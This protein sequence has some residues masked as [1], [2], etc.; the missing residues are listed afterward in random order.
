M[1]WPTDLAEVAFRYNLISPLLDPAVPKAEKKRHRRRLVTVEHSH[2]TRGSVKISARTIRRWVR[3]Y[4]LRHVQGLHKQPRRDR[5][6]HVLQPA[7]LEFATTLLR[8]NPRR[9]TGFLLEELVARFPELE[10][11]V[12]R[13]T[14]NRHLHAQGVP[15]RAVSEERAD[16][17]PY[18]RFE[19]SAPNEL[20]HSD[21]HHG[22]PAIGP[23]GNVVPTRIFAWIDDFSRVCCHCEA[24]AHES[25]PSLE[26]CFQKAMQKYGIP[27]R[28]YTDL[29]SLYSGV[30]FALICADLGIHHVPA[31]PYSPW[32]HGKIERLWG[33]Q[34]DQL[35][36]EIALL[37]PVPLAQVNKW[38]QAWVDAEYHTRRHGT[39]GEAPLD[40]WH[41]HRP[42]VTYPTEDQIQRLFWLWERR[43]VSSTGVGSQPVRSEGTVGSHFSATAYSGTRGRKTISASTTRTGELSA[44]QEW[45]PGCKARR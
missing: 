5:G 22:P 35:W 20:W 4:R 1:D 10:G 43:K 21:C 41:N 2:P 39:T 23:D 29:G 3:A 15:R 37:P 26:D 38:L 19:A 45:P 13:S 14:L 40:R 44:Q 32:T 27:S 31:R 33:L 25:L 7:H 8:E 11:R 42:I 30:Q 28:A 17:P 18:H 24:Y 34:E 12:G 9:E 36:S 16:G 6:P